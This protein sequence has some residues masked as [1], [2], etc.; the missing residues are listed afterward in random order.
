[1]AERTEGRREELEL[2]SDLAPYARNA[3]LHSQG[4]I[5]QIA[6]SIEEFGWTASVLR[7]EQGIVAG[8]GRV[9][10]ASWLYA[11]GK[12]IRFPGESEPI[13]M[14]TVPTIRCDGWSAAQRRAYVLADNQIALASGWDETLLREELLGIGDAMAALAGFSADDMARALGQLPARSAGSLA[15]A[16]MVAPFSVLNARE[17]W[18]Q[19]RKR[20]WLALGIRSELGR[21]G[22]M[23]GMN[24]HSPTI[25]QNADGSLNYGRPLG[26]DRAT[27]PWE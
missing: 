2:C 24:T 16:F 25:K 4:Q 3:R 17:G 14:G 10:G 12:R 6:R 26:A 21:G 11:H 13:P 7:D 23:Q 20:A 5:E 9:L 18:W 1:M 27:V 19:E 15:E 8:H 22:E